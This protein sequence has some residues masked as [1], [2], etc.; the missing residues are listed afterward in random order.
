MTSPTVVSPPESQVSE[1]APAPPGARWPAAIGYLALLL[2]L[3]LGFQLGG[4]AASFANV[5]FMYVPFLIL[6]TLAYLGQRY[7]A[8]KFLTILWLLALVLGA[9][10]A[11][12]GFSIAAS[13][14]ISLGGDISDASLGPEAVG[15]IQKVGAGIALSVVIGLLGYLPPVRRAASRVL[16]MRAD[17]FVHATALVAIVA[18]VLMGFVPLLVLG[19]PPLLSENIIGELGDTI[20][21]TSGLL[22]QAYVLIWSIPVAIFAVG[23]GIRRSFGATL[24][25]LGLVRPT[26][27]QV[28]LAIVVAVAMVVGVNLLEFLIDWIWTAMGWPRTDAEAFSQLIAFAFSPLGALVIAVSAGL[29]EELAVR[30]VLQPRLGIL[31]SNLFF[32]SLHAFQY[33][34]DSL[35]VVFL[36]GIIF[37]LMRV[38][39]NTTTT[40]I[41][42]GLY[43]YILVMMAVYEISLFP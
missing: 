15:I 12:V 35:L 14:A 9:S 6:A 3:P 41:A 40:A 33:S 32:T 39:T 23:Y 21:E 2:A 26:L 29:G 17:S 28:G 19:A 4:E 10:I 16:P 38:R 20:S 22:S 25:R 27:R 42:H 37:G 34:W 43:D 11:F 1:P 7:G 8:G 18:F 24:Q 31:L 13:G 5:G 30:G 36:L